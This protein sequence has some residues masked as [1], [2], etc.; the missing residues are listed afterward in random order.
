MI[1][2]CDLLPFPYFCQAFELLMKYRHSI[3]IPYQDVDATRRLRLYTMEN[4]LLNIAGKVADGMGIGI[5]ALLPMNYTWI[6]THM[7]IEM[8]YLPKHGEE[9]IVETW[10]ERN[11]HMLSVRDFRI[12][13][14]ASDGAEQFIGCAKSVWAV[15]DL[16]SREIVNIFD[17]PMFEGAVDGELLN[18][19]RAPR[20]KPILLDNLENAEAT[21]GEIMHEIQYSDVDYNCHCNSCKYLE[22][23]VNAIQAFDNKKPF[24]LDINYVK[25]LYQ[26]DVMYTRFLKTKDAVQYQQVDVDGKT[27][28]NAMIS[29]IENVSC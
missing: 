24:R 6:I 7:N 21:T 5:P 12:Y 14:P 10:I 4:Y 11:A 15:L 9:I 17:H 22:W 23:M 8:L 1:L 3:I 19:T 28:C 18:M 13:K 16:T 26:G 20:F 29:Q 27:C 25:E 2:L